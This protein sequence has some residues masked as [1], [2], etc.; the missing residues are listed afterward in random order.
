MGRVGP[1][2][3]G[4][5]APFLASG[6]PVPRFLSPPHGSPVRFGTPVC[7][8]SLGS[9]RSPLGSSLLDVTEGAVGSFSGPLPVLGSSLLDET[10][11]AVEPTQGISP[12][13]T[14][15][16]VSSP[17]LGEGGRIRGVRIRKVAGQRRSVRLRPSSSSCASYSSP[18]PAAACSLCALC[19]ARLKI[20]GTSTLEFCERCLSELLPFN[21]FSNN[22]NFREA[23]LGFFENRRHLGNNSELLFNPL[24]EELKDTLVDLNRTLGGCKY[25]N[26]SQFCKFRQNFFKGKKK[27]ALITL[28]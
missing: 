16:W 26:E 12:H 3:L 18:S 11:E 14:Q 22:R 2:P 15:R 1:P 7:S 13:R 9:A 4:T 23:I 25:Y 21:H 10:V 20:N 17:L 8:V 28:S 19:Q 27:S 24:D 5:P 6:P